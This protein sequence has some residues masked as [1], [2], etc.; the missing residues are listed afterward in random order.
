MS[1]ERGD[2]GGWLNGP[3]TSADS[4]PGKSLG[5]P[6]DGP[7]SIA[8]LGRRIG[9]LIID[10]VACSVISAA[11]IHGSSTG[12]L[13]IFIAEQILLVG[14]FGTSLGHRIFRIRV[15]GVRGTTS[16]MDRAPYFARAVVRSVLLALFV[17]AL[18]MNRDMRGLNDRIAGL[19]V[20]RG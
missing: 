4:W 3:E 8:S 19:V 11:F 17:P 9:A 14:L 7:G 12:T 6:M 18:L 15:E 1:F 16:P 10:W 2:L 13:L 5:Y 20:V